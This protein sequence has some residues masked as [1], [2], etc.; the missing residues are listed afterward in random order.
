MKKLNEK[1]VKEIVEK[2]G[3]SKSQKFRKLYELG[4]EV[5]DIAKTMNSHY[6]FVYGVIERGFGEVKSER[7]SKKSKSERMKEM[8]DEGKTIG[9]ISREL[10][11]NYSYTWRV[12]NKYRNEMK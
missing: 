10:E 6:S 7:K 5:K 12:I 2:E 9:Q 8:Y 3:I 4:M 11:T 1:K